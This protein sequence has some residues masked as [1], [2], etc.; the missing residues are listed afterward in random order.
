VAPTVLDVW[1]NETDEVLRQFTLGLIL[2]GMRSGGAEA[3]EASITHRDE[4]GMT[5]R[6]S[7]KEKA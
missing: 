1:F 7:W 6:A 2:A 3:P 5:I 4:Q